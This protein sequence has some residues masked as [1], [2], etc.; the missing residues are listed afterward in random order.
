MSALN[1]RELIK[2][3]A[4]LAL[5]T[6][7]SSSP[8]WAAPLGANPFMLG[9]ASGDPWPDGFVIWPRLA[10]RPLEEH[11]GMP[12][13]RVPVRWEVAEDM[14]FSKVVR[15]GEAMALP[16]LAHSVHVEVAGLRPHRH[17]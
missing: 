2:A 13:A 11:A 6:G 4:S 12:A 5:F 9:V 17:Y 15:Q 1:R 10:P 8:L 16:E 3:S 7:F 14:A